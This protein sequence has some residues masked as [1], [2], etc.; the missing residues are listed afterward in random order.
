MAEKADPKL[1]DTTHQMLVEQFQEY[2]DGT[3]Q[4]RQLAEKCRDYRDGNQWTAEERE[5]LKKRKQPC[6]TDNKIQDKC[7]TLLGIEKQMRTDPKAFP[8]NPQDEGSAEAATDALRYVADQNLYHQT[9][10]KPAA[11]NLMVEGLCGGQVVVEKRKGAQTKICMEHIRWD[12]LYYDLRSLRDD[13][14]DSSYK[15]YFTWMDYEVAIDK[16]EDAKDVLDA[17]FGGQSQ[18]GPD[19]ALDD[20]PRFVLT[21]RNRKR[22]QV[23]TTYFK[24]KGKWMFAVWCRGG[25]LDKPRASAYKDEYGQPDC[26]IELQALYRDSEG[27]PY[28]SVQRY[29]DLQDEHNKRRSKMLHLLNSKR[30]VVRKGEVDDIQKLRTEAHKP[31]GV[32]EVAG[33]IAQLRVED[34]LKEAEGQWR[35]LQQTDVALSQTGPNNAIAGTSGDL[36]GI[37]KARDQ[38]AGQLPISPLFEALDS[39][40]LRMYRGVWKRVRQYWTAEMWIRVTDDEDKIRFVGLNQP[41]LMGDK[42]AQ[43]AAKDPQFQQ[44]APEEQQGVIHEIASRP[45]AQQQSLDDKTGKPLRKNDVAQMDMDI[46]IDRGQDVVTV[47]Q[48]E[49][50]MLAEI[51]KGRP[52]IPFDVLI[53][54]SQLRSDTKKRVV[55]RMKG[56]DDPAAAQ[57]A[58]FQQ[59]MQQLQGLVMQAQVRRENA[60]ASKDEAAA[61]ESKIDAAVKVAEFTTPADPA[62]GQPGAKPAGKTTVSVN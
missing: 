25:W 41:V 27:S 53:E 49:F 54:M 58:Q 2:A 55:D 10:R 38:Q 1:T 20:K 13:F 22:V 61:E 37:A 6:I 50:G 62:T 17:S 42:L 34:N 8:R 3:Y 43:A 4:A 12:R 14:E 23:F 45:E 60:S 7:D 57:Q 47:Q 46:I 5:I 40:E 19:K 9:T 29:L 11:D 33:D 18:S 15:G 30:I 51:A 31:D 44:L 39:W 21:L 35:L 48:E 28:G 52:E 32:M 56:A 59:M 16:W 24:Q 36:S 26:P